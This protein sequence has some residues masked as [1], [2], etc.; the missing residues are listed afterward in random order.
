MPTMYIFPGKDTEWKI[1]RVSELELIT[2]VGRIQSDKISIYTKHELMLSVS[3]CKGY[4]VGI[5]G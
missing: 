5:G 2:T 1:S 3:V 4:V